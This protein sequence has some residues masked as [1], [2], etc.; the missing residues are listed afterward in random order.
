MPR[1]TIT[2]IA[3]H[4]G[5]HKSTVSRQVRRHHLV[6]ADGLA[7]LDAY[8]ALRASGIDPALQTSDTAA[9]VGGD[10]KSLAAE[11][12]RKM[13]AD[14]ELAELELARQK[15][16][17]VQ[18]RDVE[19]A[20][21]DIA[22]KVRQAVMDVARNEAAALVLLADEQAIEGHLVLALAAALDSVRDPDTDDMGRAS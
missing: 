10:E 13:S 1:L 7:D 9:I 22:R 15:H 11:R 20:Q 21:E 16:E 8:L 19:T 18:V 2:E 3:A 4:A 14:A 17:L 5:V 6:G 12:K